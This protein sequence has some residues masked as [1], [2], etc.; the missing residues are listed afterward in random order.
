MFQQFAQQQTHSSVFRPRDDKGMKP[1]WSV[2]LKF[3]LRESCQRIR[4]IIFRKS[5]PKNIVMFVKTFRMACL[6][7]SGAFKCSL[8]YHCI[9]FTRKLFSPS[10]YF[11]FYREWN[12][13]RSIRAQ[14]LTVD[15]AAFVLWPLKAAAKERDKIQLL[16][17]AL[18]SVRRWRF[19]SHSPQRQTIFK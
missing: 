4:E 13:K 7:K 10:F 2:L 17:L 19:P 6:W 12:C 9:Q 3:Y 8:Y 14:L 15:E 18:L 1:P 5:S 11:P 16:K